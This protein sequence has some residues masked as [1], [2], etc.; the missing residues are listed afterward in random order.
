[1]DEALASTLRPAYMRA[2]VPALAVSAAGMVACA[3]AAG[4]GSLGFFLGA[5]AMLAISIPPLVAGQERLIDRLLAAG[6]AADGVAA[7]AI[8]AVFAGACSWGQWLQVYVLA[9][10][11]AAMLMAFVHLLIEVRVNRWAAAGMAV[12]FSFAWLLWPIWLSPVLT[13][14]L[15]N[16]LTPCHPLFAM[17]A[18]VRHLGL[19]SEQAGVVYHLTSLN[20][21]IPH[22]LPASAWPAIAAH[23]LLAAMLLLLSRLLRRQPASR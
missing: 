10:A 16:W 21:D 2:Y 13:A 4:A 8:F 9:I 12:L 7:G 23:L 19:W 15:A 11:W 3:T 6:G 20:Q 18:V 14:A 1:M 17:N 5:M 22:R